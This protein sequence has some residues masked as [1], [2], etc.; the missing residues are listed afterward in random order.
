MAD[1]ARPDRDPGFATHGLA[2]VLRLGMAVRRD[3]DRYAPASATVLFLVNAHDHTVKTAPV[4]DLARRWARQAVPVSVY[5]LPD[6]L[7]FAHNIVDPIQPEP[8]SALV[9][10]LLEALAQGDE[11]PRWLTRR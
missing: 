3:A 10:P 2:A 1:L 7:G 5:E 11:P 9:Y 6:S 8:N 4:V